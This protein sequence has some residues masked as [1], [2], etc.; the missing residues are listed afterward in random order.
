M[1]IDYHMPR[2]FQVERSVIASNQSD[3]YQYIG[4]ASS[5]LNASSVKCSCFELGKKKNKCLCDANA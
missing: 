5:L 1:N 4:M 3:M 2:L